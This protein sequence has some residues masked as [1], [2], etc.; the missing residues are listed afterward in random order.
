MGYQIRIPRVAITQSFFFLFFFFFFYFIPFQGDEDCCLLNSQSCLMSFFI[1]YQLFCSNHFSISV[2]IFEA[3]IYNITKPLVRILLNSLV[4]SWSK[5]FNHGLNHNSKI[6]T[7]H[8]FCFLP[9]LLLI[10]QYDWLICH[11][12]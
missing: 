3:F 7:A 5:T 12:R 1:I 2:F 6:H 8:Q 11:G 4:C 9:Q 10:S